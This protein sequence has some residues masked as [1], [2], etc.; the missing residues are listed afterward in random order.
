MDQATLYT[1]GEFKP[2]W[3]TLDEIRANI[4]SSYHPG[5]ERRKL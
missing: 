2:A 1:R 3:V 4:E 5:E